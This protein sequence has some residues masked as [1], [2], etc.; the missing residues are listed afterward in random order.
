[1][2][3][4]TVLTVL[5]P[6]LAAILWN[7][8]ELQGWAR[9]H[10]GRW[11]A[12]EKLEMEIHEL[13]EYCDCVEEHLAREPQKKQLRAD[14]GAGRNVAATA[15]VLLLL[16][17]GTTLRAAECRNQIWVDYSGSPSSVEM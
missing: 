1:S 11:R 3:L 12:L 4:I 9:K 6:M 15:A 7:F 2:L 10:V 13:K 5:S 17:C 8:G 14:D 16:H